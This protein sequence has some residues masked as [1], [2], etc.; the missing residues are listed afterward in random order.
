MARLF[1]KILPQPSKQQMVVLE[2][3][4][5]ISVFHHCPIEKLVLIVSEVQIEVPQH[6]TQHVIPIRIN[7]TNIKHCIF[8]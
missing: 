1:T 4:R 2:T 5:P 6:S 7:I 8:K 3:Y